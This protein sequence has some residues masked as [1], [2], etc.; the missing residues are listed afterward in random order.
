MGN[1]DLS[2]FFA[3][4]NQEPITYSLSGRSVIDFLDIGIDPL[5]NL[6]GNRWL[7]R[8]GSLFVV[9]PSGHGKSSFCIQ[10]Q[11]CWAMGR[12]A[13]GLKPA[14]PLRILAI[15]SED[16]DAENK[17]FV[18]VLHTMNLSSAEWDM[19]HQNTRLEFR[20]DL[21]GNRFFDAVDQ[22]LTQWPADILLINPLTGFCS[23][24]LRDDAAMEDFLRNKLNSLCTSHSCAP[25][26]VAHMPKGEVNQIKD[27]AWYEWMYVLSG[28]VTLTNW[29]RAIL[30]FVPSQTPGTYRF[31]T[32]KRPAQS[33]W[34]EPECYFAHSKT[35][36]QL[37]NHPLEV[38]QWIP[39][40]STQVLEA[41]PV[42][43]KTARREYTCA[44]I[45]AKMSPFEQY[46]RDKFRSWCK[47]SFNMG[48][49]ASDRIRKTLIDDGLIELIEI[50][51]K[52]FLKT[53]LFRKIPK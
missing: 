11:I 35:I 47:E 50:P 42:P 9:A 21:C 36:L 4:F 22:F 28:C 7:T 40:T 39:A 8:E 24:S 5:T 10:C 53:S 6:I 15:Q 20:R 29:A 26:I 3:S 41:K 49:M 30:V 19:I 17:A 2:E 46:S 52:G 45:Y 31:I 27:K 25:M 34:I 23:A 43:K 1:N 37:D 18:Q 12:V 38:I 16:E 33:G 32:A 48:V 44:E 13:F 14:R 51:I